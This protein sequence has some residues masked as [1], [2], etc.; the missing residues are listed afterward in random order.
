MSLE[1]AKSSNLF[2]DTLS[3]LLRKPSSKV[4]RGGRQDPVTS[5]KVVPVASSSDSRLNGDDPYDPVAE[6]KTGPLQHHPGTNDAEVNCHQPQASCK[7]M[8]PSCM[9]GS[10]FTSHIFAAY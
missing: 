10:Q 2:K 7:L 1:P 8:S 4:G 5:S 9:S 6:W 3:K